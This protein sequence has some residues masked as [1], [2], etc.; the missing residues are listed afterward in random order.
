MLERGGGLRVL[1]LLLW[2][3][4]LIVA[5]L[6]TQAVVV[7]HQARTRGLPD[8]FPAPVAGADVPILGVNVALEQYDDEAL[9]AALAR[10]AEG[11]FTWIR[12]SFYW[13][14][15]EPE[16]GRHDWSTPDR[17]MAAL[18]RYPQLRLVVVLDD[19]PPVPPA[20]PA[21]FAAFA[22][23]FATRYG[24]QVDDYQVWDE[25]NL[26][27]HWGGGPINPPAYADLLARTARA[28]RTA[29]RS[30]QGRHGRP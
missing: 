14:L 18:A 15:I 23:E 7:E 20:D 17:I 26:A 25:P 19:S 16:P 4:L 10:V 29:D 9:S 22:R 5:G 1:R 3:A 13:S 21:R 30:A 12:Q 28:I 11:G 8:G 27:A 6:V 2:L 24:A